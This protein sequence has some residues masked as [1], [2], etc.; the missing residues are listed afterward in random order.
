LYIL[1]TV[2]R[3]YIPAARAGFKKIIWGLHILAGRCVCCAEAVAMNIQPG[4]RPLVEG[5]TD[6]A[7]KMIVEGFSVL[8]GMCDG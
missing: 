2:T 6:L 4:S 3:N 8:E 7:R 5:D 1:P